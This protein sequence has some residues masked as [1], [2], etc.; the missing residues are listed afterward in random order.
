MCTKSEKDRVCVD[1]TMY[2]NPLS[3][4][5]TVSKQDRC[6]AWSGLL[7]G[8]DS[9]KVSDF[10]TILDINSNVMTISNIY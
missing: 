8:A 9:P 6:Y 5:T 10:N 3:K 1:F 2:M 7:H 4:E